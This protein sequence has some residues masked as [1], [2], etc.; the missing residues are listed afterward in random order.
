VILPLLRGETARCASGEHIRDFLHVE[1]AACAVRAV[2]TSEFTG[3]INIGSGEPVKL[4]TIVE[5]IAGIA[6]AGE[7]AVFAALPDTPSEPPLLVADVHKLARSIGWRAARDLRQGLRQ[8]VNW[9]KSQIANQQR[10]D[11]SERH[12][13]GT[14]SRASGQIQ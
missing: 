3:A 7:R 2:S 5:T 12:L 13:R 14:A 6:D 11:W 8:T 1:D 4:R 9:W 10:E